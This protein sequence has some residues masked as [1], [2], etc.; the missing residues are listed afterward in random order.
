MTWTPGPWH[1]ETKTDSLFTHD[2]APF[3]RVVAGDEN[4]GVYPHKEADARL[5]AAAPEMAELLEENYGPLLAGDWYADYDA[6]SERLGR[7]RALL[8]RIR[9]EA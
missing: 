4:L 6:A 8:S 9:G 7:I 2:S 3:H 1:V 5:I